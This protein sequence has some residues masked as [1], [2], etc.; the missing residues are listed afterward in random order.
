MAELE[1]VRVDQDGASL[2][3]RD[4][5]GTEHA[6]PVTDALRVAVARPRRPAEPSATPPVPVA[7]ADGEPSL[8]PRDLQARMRAG[9]SAEELAA[10]AGLPVENVRRYEWPVV[11]ERE[12]VIGMVRTHDVPGLDGTSEL[13]KIADAR[14]AARGVKPDDAAW[15]A[16]REGSAPWV[17]EVRFSA[18]DRERSARWTF[19]LRGRVVTPLDDEA[20]W[21]GQPDDPLTPEVRGVPSLAARR[22]VPPADA[23]TDLLLDDLAGRRGQRPPSRAHRPATSS[24]PV[25]SP[26]TPPPAAGSDDGDGGFQ[27]VPLGEVPVRERPP[28]RATG[29]EP[30]AEDEP[31]G[32]S[33][34]DLGRWN[35]RRTRDRS[36]SPGGGPRGSQPALLTPSGAPTASAS[37][38]TED[39]PDDDA[40]K[41]AATARPGTPA[42]GVPAARRKGRA[43]VPSWDEIVFGARPE[44]S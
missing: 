34:V 13:G 6:L 23:E 15:T 3:L 30:D 35:P 8:R 11:T 2:V 1:L 20:R 33:V 29:P 5:D 39:A 28:V 40:A 12:H 26:L 19:D 24:L 42:R 31:A 4:P 22:S 25:V 9:A 16:R 14:L 27:T 37:P 17:V 21:L 41:P 10:E 44:P 32:A 36:V 38:E 18:G 43:Q 7:T